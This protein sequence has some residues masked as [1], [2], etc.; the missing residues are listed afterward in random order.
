M[1]THKKLKIWTIILHGL[2]L[3]AGGHG[4]AQLFIV[5]VMGMLDIKELFLSSSINKKH[6]AVVSLAILL[7]QVTIVISLFITQ[8]RQQLLL[9]L[10][11]LSLLWFSVIY[12]AYIHIVWITVVPFFI[13]TMLT[14]TG[15]YL[16]RFYNWLGDNL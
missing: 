5:E 1:L 4:V 10:S 15:K 16:K 14:L 6:I 3:I 8:K 13:C 11:G 9:H 7:G 12:C 2:I